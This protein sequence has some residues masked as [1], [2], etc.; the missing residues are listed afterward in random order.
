MN[1]DTPREAQAAAQGSPPRACK[2]PGD[3]VALEPDDDT[4]RGALRL[5]CESCFTVWLDL[6]D[7]DDD[8]QDTDAFQ[9]A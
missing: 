7:D 6:P 9:A 2:H 1:G 5:L 3:Q 4:P 8:A